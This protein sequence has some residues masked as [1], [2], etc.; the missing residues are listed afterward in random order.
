M[1]VMHSSR[2]D[3]WMTPVWLI[4]KCHAVLG[5]IYLDPASDETANKRVG[6]ARYYDRDQDGLEQ[7]W[8]GNVFCNPPGGKRGNQSMTALFWQKLM[9]ERS[10][11]LIRHAIFLCFSAEALQNT[12]AKGCESVMQFPICVPSKRIRFDHPGPFEK[13]APSHSNVIVYVPCEIDRTKDFVREFSEIGA[14]KI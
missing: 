5:D 11:G 6:A 4:E 8:H 7:L 1:N 9:A 13:T 3:S 2:N 14:V 10:R 12:Q